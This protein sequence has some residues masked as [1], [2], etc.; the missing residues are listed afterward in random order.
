MK[1]QVVFLF[2]SLKQTSAVE[3]ALYS[4]SDKLHAWLHVVILPIWQ[5]AT[6]SMIAALFLYFRDLL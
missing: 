3:G 4:M 6:H 5:W 2:G 1:Q